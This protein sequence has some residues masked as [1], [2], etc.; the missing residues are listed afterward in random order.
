M[1]PI[2]PQTVKNGHRKKY[3]FC[4]ARVGIDP[5]TFTFLSAMRYKKK[6]VPINKLTKKIRDATNCAKASGW[7]CSG[8]W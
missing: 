3:H 6:S 5:H 4:F 2:A 1:Q 7:C 8:W